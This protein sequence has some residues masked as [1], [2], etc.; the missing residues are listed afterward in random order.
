M[1]VRVPRLVRMHSEEMEDIQ[2][3]KAGDIVAIF[4]V[5]CASGGEVAGAGAGGRQEAKVGD[6]VAIFGVDC[7]S[8][9]EGSHEVQVNGPKGAGRRQRRATSWRS[10][11]FDCASGGEYTH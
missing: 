2:E 10:L 3:A 1:Q 8:G 6:I 5:D 11:A 7:A 4:G 9:G